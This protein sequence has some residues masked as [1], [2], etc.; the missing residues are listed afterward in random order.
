MDPAT[1][2][3][4]IVQSITFVLLVVSETLPIA[5]TPYNGIVQGL[6]HYFQSLQVPKPPPTIVVATPT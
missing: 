3:L 2:S 4:I 5:N 1:V 6:L